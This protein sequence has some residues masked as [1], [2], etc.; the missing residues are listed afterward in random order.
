[1]T[2]MQRAVVRVVRAGGKWR[3]GASVLFP[4]D[5]NWGARAYRAMWPDAIRSLTL[6]KDRADGKD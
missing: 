4:D 1:M 6:R 3:S 2:S 5:L